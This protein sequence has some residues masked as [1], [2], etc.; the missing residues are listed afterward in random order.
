MMARC[1]AVVVL[2]AT[3]CSSLFGLKD[4]TPRDGNGDDD[5]IDAPLCWGTEVRV[6]LQ[7]EPTGVLSLSDTLD[8]GTLA[9]GN[10]TAPCQPYSGPDGLCVIAGASVEIGSGVGVTFTGE[11][12][13]VMIATT[14][15]DVGGT[16]D[17]GSHAAQ[18]G[19]GASLVGTDPVACPVF[20]TKPSSHGGGAGGSLGGPGG[21]GGGNED[22]H[23]GVVGVAPPATGLRAGCPGQDGGSA[24]QGFGLG[25]YGGGAIEIIAGTSITIGGR[26]DASGTGGIGGRCV[27]ACNN[28]DPST[29]A[30][31]GGGAGAGG[32][33]LLEA[34]SITAT[35]MVFA[36]GGGGGEG[37][38][39]TIDGANGTD[40]MGT[41][42]AL[43]GNA[44]DHAGQGGTGSY[45]TALFGAVGGDGKKSGTI[46]AGGGGGGGGGPGAIRVHG[47][48]SIDGVGDGLSGVVSPPASF[49]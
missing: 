27:G 1:F 29:N 2:F 23:G 45:T 17:V 9:G 22:D 6:C 41:T 21:N 39:H 5:Q 43:G 46:P 35:G 36:D 38:S 32:T 33:I 26:V 7:T 11:R 30:D 4:S 16:V 8:T 49:P 40:P 20:A 44:T 42:A 37:A 3:G 34:P 19:P 15:F 47:A 31:G 25:G 24:G 12:A 13:V 10:A 48:S 18:F 28:T 14:T